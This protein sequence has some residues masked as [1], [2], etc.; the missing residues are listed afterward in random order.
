MAKNL[1][2]KCKL[3]RR[4]GEKLFLK[5]DRCAT[6]KC[7][8]VRKA[9]KPGMHGPK[10]E[11]RGLS[12]YGSQLKE[13][14]K[15]KRSYGLS[16]QQFRKHLV[17][18]QSKQGV[19]G[20]NLMSRLEMRLDNVVYRLG[21]ASSRSQARQMVSHKAF[22]LNGRSLNIPSAEVKVGDEI[23]VK[24]HKA[25]RKYFK[26]LQLVLK[27]GANIPK[28]L[29]LDPAELKGKVLSNPTREEIGLGFD[30]ASVIEFYSR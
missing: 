3:C 9:Y 12:D 16:E 4:A 10:G 24:K 13:K 2:S 29:S 30:L 27:G 6:P 5:G 7:A 14:Q 20:D 28:W 8:L 17:E 21:F 23:Q 25:D 11:G 26:D 19:V 1:G 18:A 22:L 15:L